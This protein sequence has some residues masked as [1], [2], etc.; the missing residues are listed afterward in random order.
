MSKD[1]GPANRFELDDRYAVGCFRVPVPG[2]TDKAWMITDGVRQ[3]LATARGQSLKESKHQW[4]REHQPAPGTY[5][6][7]KYMPMR[8]T[9]LAMT[10]GFL[11]RYNYPV[12]YAATLREKLA[13]MVAAE[14]AAIAAS[15]G[16]V[17]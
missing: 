11:Y 13:R 17:S 3:S 12:E 7:V 6:F 2:R 4:E 16:D 1:H 15:K 14:E 8:D 5:V 10:K 9:A